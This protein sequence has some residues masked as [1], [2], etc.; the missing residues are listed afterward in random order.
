MKAHRYFVDSRTGCIAVRDNENTDK[1]YQGLH[2]DTQGVVWYRHGVNVV[3]KCPTCGQNTHAK[4][5]VAGI[6]VSDAHNLCAELNAGA[7]LNATVQKYG[8]K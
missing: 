4:W 3:D 7:D 2:P 8:G 1:E 5:E 6:H